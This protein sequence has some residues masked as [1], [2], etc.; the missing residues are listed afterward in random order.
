MQSSNGQMSYAML[1]RTR[2]APLNTLFYTKIVVYEA[3]SYEDYSKS[4]SFCNSFSFCIFFNGELSPPVVV[5]FLINCLYQEEQVLV[6]SFLI[7]LSSQSPYISPLLLLSSQSHMR[8]ITYIVWLLKSSLEI[9]QSLCCQIFYFC[10]L[11]SFTIKRFKS[12]YHLEY[13]VLL[14]KVFRFNTE[15]VPVLSFFFHSFSEL[16]CID[17]L[18]FFKVLS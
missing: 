6:L 2:Q 16:T 18:L 5:C 14:F 1:L 9:L 12:L 11:A 4:L 3:S 17:R 8:P 15:I 7:T 10:Y 13:T